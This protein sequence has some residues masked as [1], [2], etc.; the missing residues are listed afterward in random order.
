[1][2]IFNRVFDVSYMYLQD[3]VLELEFQGVKKQ[4]T[5]LQVQNPFCF[6]AR[7]FRVFFLATV[8]CYCKLYFILVCMFAE[9]A[10]TFTKAC[11]IKACCWYPSTYWAGRLNVYSVESYFFW[12]CW[13]WRIYFCVSVFLMPFSPLFLVALVPFLEHL[14][15]E[16]QLLVKLFQ[17]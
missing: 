16:K 6:L 2:N 12:M 15:V 11:R 17:R 4:F 8:V 9:L 5:M 13:F 3:T 10:C 7:A 14:V 1:M